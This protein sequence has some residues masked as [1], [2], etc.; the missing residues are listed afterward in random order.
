MYTHVTWDTPIPSSQHLPEWGVLPTSCPQPEVPLL[1][2]WFLC[3]LCIL[4]CIYQNVPRTSACSNKF[5]FC[6]RVRQHLSLCFQYFLSN[7]FCYCWFPEVVILDWT[8]A[9]R[10]LHFCRG[11]HQF[12]LSPPTPRRFWIISPELFLPALIRSLLLI[13]PVHSTL[14]IFYY[15]EE[16]SPMHKF[17]NSPWY[18]LSP[19][20]WK[21]VNKFSSTC[22]PMGRRVC[23]Y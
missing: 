8:Q 13:P 3:P 4:R 21:N 5:L 10:F 7:K 16:L 23:Y 18:F 11:Y 22:L 19:Y 20:L 12:L 2:P 15:M 17:G 14:T 6:P 1:P 9:T